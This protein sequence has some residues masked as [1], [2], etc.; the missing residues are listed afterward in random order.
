[1]L[2]FFIPS[3]LAIFII[4]NIEKKWCSTLPVVSK[5]EKVKINSVRFSVSS[6]EGEGYKKS[7]KKATKSKSHR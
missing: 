5:S 4:W 6:L 2:G 3:E 1:M 7:S